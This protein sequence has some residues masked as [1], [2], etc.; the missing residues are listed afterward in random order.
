MLFRSADM[1]RLE[2]HGLEVDSGKTITG[3]MDRL[4]HGMSSGCD[5]LL[6]VDRGG[7]EELSMVEPLMREVRMNAR[8]SHES[9]RECTDEEELGFELMEQGC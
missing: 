6:P 4:G 3:D 1:A 8:V 2:H 7:W 9:K 5:A